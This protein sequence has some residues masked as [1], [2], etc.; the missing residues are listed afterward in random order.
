M[1][2][3]EISEMKREYFEIDSMS[4]GGRLHLACTSHTMVALLQK[5]P[6]L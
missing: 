6:P 5:F 4:G 3:S 1:E 2:G